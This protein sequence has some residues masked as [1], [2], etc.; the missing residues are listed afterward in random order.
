MPQN[1]HEPP[2]ITINTLSPDGVAVVRE[3]SL[4]DTFVA[5]IQVSSDV[6]DVVCM[7]NSQDFRLEML[8]EGEYKLT[9]EWVFD[10]EEK[11][12]YNLVI[13]CIDDGQPPLEASKSL[14]VIVA[15]EN[16][17][18]PLFLKSSYSATVP[19][20][21]PEGTPLLQVEAVD[22]DE[23]ENAKISYSMMEYA[24]DL[25]RID[26]ATGLITTKITFD[27][28]DMHRY[29]F[30]VIAVD[31]GSVP[32][33]STAMVYVYIEDINDEKPIFTQPVYKFGVFEDAA[34][35]TEFGQVTAYD[36]DREPFN[37]V[38]YS[39]ANDESG[40]FNIGAESGIITTSAEL[41]PQETT[42]MYEFEV[43]AS[44]QEEWESN[45]AT[46]SVYVLKDVTL[47]RK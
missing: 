41:D 29:D 6:G 16:D 19:E 40:K 25:F 18:A 38:E 24:N 10:R 44:G 20:N 45:M 11:Q 32:L 42:E 17:Q 39:I 7:L 47:E 28:E 5:H 12:D 22:L 21:A 30:E 2:E 14:Q 46:V 35:G 1:D 43:V 8:Y 23:M 4:P 27:A 13:T 9:T 33:S 37:V 3:N 36:A 34:I 15:D 31:H 26:S